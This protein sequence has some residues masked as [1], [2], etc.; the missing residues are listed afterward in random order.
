M[1][2]VLDSSVTLARVFPDEWTPAV[3]QVFDDHVV[4]GAWVPDIWKIELANVLLF[5]VK[6]GRMTKNRRDEALSDLQFLPISIDTETGKRA[7][8]ET[9]ALADRHQLTVYD[10]TYLE[11]AMRL[12]LPLATLDR[13][14]RNA[15]Q[16]EGVALLGI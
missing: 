6:K 8:K 15:A 4:H 13:D 10:A 11:L 3:L 12:S 16:A 2:L 14:L 7:W 5:S 1:S 9:I